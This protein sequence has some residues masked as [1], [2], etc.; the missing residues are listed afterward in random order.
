MN[1]DA[2]SRFILD[3]IEDIVY[4]AD[5]ITNE[6]YYMNA[7]C[8]EVL[9][10]PEEDQWRRKKCYKILQGLDEPCPFCTN[11]CLNHDSFYNWEHYNE[12]LDIYFM[13]QDKLI[14]FDGIEARIEI[15]KDISKLKLLEQGL[16]QQ[17]AQ[18]QVINDCICTLH[19]GLTPDEAIDELLNHVAMY[20]MAERSYIFDLSDDKKYINNTYEWCAQ[21]VV[22]QIDFLQNV[23]SSVVANW[24]EKYDE[25]GEFYIDSLSDELD[26]ESEEYRILQAQDI[27]S[28]VTAPLRDVSGNIIG[29]IGVDNP[30]QNIKKTFVIR[31]ISNFISDFLDKNQVIEKLNQLSFNDSLT[32]LKNRHS[33]TNEIIALQKQKT[34]SLGIIYIDINGLKVVNDQY[35]HKY[36][37]LYIT[38]LSDILK[39]SFGEHAYRIGGDEFVVILPD[40]EQVTLETE[41]KELQAVLNSGESPKAAIGYSW[42]NTWDVTTQIEKADNLMYQEKQRQYRENFDKDI[43]FRGKYEV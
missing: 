41:V 36:G 42:S 19:S 39:K 18:Q 20:H 9:G 15:A 26:V 10:N 29:F 16:T 35:G 22:P 3:V 12:L 37:D 27:T 7:K 1:A 31:S 17:L 6:L 38:S 34:A 14:N 8:L 4:I 30:T 40:V 23:D 13:V 24:F 25:V 28:L 2:V 43:I 11:H 5:P 21:G 33:Y 32:G